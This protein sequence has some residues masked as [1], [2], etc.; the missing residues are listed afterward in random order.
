AVAAVLRAGLRTA[1]IQT[2]GGKAV[3]TEEMGDAVVAAL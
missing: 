2:A 1:D 3:S